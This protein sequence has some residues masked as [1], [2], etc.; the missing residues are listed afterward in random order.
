MS[1]CHKLETD[2]HRIDVVPHAFVIV[3]LYA[4]IKV[5]FGCY[6]MDC[7]VSVAVVPPI[8]VVIHFDIAVARAC[9][10]DAP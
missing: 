10:V 9:G 8:A 1:A 2:A 3:C 5:K 6:M 4:L 7:I